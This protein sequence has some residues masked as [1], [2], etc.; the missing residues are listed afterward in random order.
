M[1]GIVLGIIYRVKRLTRLNYLYPQGRV[2]L[3][4]INIRNKKDVNLVVRSSKLHKNFKTSKLQ[5][6]ID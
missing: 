5:V 6:L 1:V 2:F 3:Y 4:L